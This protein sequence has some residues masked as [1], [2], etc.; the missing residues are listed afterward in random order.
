MVENTKEK[1][2]Y[3]SNPL[4]IIALFVFFIETINATTIYFLKGQPELLKYV[5]I[6]IIT[7][8][9][10]IA[11]LF[12]I[13]LWKKPQ[14]FYTPSDYKEDK[15]FLEAIFK[16]LKFEQQ[17]FQAT[18]SPPSNPNTV[19]VLVDDLIEKKEFLNVVRIGRGYLKLKEYVKCLQFFEYVKEK[20]N[21]SEDFYVTMLANCAYSLIGLKDYSKAL[22]YLLE[23]KSILKD[24]ME[25]WHLVPLAYC[26]FGVGKQKEFNLTIQEANLHPKMDEEIEEF[27][28]RYPEIADRLTL[29]N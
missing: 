26:Y 25:V 29:P 1:I 2:Y 27:K 3:P 14:A 23:V 6:F 16:E 18:I 8:P 4:G 22:D 11:I 24:K 10:I 17:V 20:I 12:F 15:S 19:F 9:S 28:I 13:F 21:K 5:V 7:F